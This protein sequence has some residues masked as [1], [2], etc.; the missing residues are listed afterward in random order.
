MTLSI[1]SVQ[2][3][4]QYSPLQIRGQYSPLQLRGQHNPLQLRGQYSPLQLRGQY[5]PLQLILK[6]HNEMAHSKFH[7]VSDMWLNNIRKNSS[8]LFFVLNLLMSCI[9][10]SA[11]K[12][13]TSLAFP[14]QNL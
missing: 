10:Y 13:K 3:R 11:E 7:V 5:S 2:L 6:Q 12:C 1:P 4:G 8:L 14:W 9:V